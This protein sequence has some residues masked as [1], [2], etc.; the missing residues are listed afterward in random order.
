MHMDCQTACREYG[1]VVVTVFLI[2]LVVLEHVMVCSSYF[3]A[4]DIFMFRK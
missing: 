1:F 2:I 3:I 4:G